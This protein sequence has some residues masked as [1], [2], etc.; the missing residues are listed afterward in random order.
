[1]SFGDAALVRK[2]VDNLSEED[3][4]NLQKTLRDVA[5]DKSAKGYAAIAA[6]HG[7]PAQCKDSNN[8]PVA[9]CVHG[10]P[11]FPQWHRLYVV[12][13]EQA[14]KEK[15]L[16]IGIPYWDWTR[17]L[18]KLPDL[19]SQQVFIESDGTKAKKNVWYQGDIEVVENS[20]TVIR[21]TARALDDRL[22]QK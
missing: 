1:L 2:N 14:L 11:V 9:C 20:K 22:F 13:L 16:S 12:Q 21:H 5:D 4:I 19:V 8:H 7:Y 6:Y 3:I 15:G 10:M 17:P 18:T